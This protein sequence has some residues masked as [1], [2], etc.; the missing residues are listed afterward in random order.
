[1]RQYAGGR[2]RWQPEAL[3]R[4]RA[5]ALGTSLAFVVEATGAFAARTPAENAT[6]RHAAVGYATNVAGAARA[7]AIDIGF[8]EGRILL[9]VLAVRGHAHVER[10]TEPEHGAVVGMADEPGGA[11]GVSVAVAFA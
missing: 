10:V 11:F 2:P 1:M 4:L 8:A 7:A 9:T 6:V 3:A 5:P